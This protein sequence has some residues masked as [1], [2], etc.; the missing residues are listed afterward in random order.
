MTRKHRTHQHSGAVAVRHLSNDTIV[1]VAQLLQEQV[2]A[3][4]RF[5]VELDWFALDTDLMARDVTADV[6]L[7]RVAHGIMLRAKIA[8]TAM[9]ECVRCLEMYDQPF[10]AEAEQLYR[11]ILDL[12]HGFVV[13]EDEEDGPD[14]FDGDVGE[15]DDINEMDF[16]EPI[17]QF[18]ILSLPMQPT[19]GDDCPGPPVDLSGDDEIDRRFAPLAALLEDAPDAENNEE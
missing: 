3:T 8:G 13:G 19:C 5:K 18:A 14:G 6:E 2:G 17:R 7:M 16:A 4:R 9:I 10:V 1:N 15:I 11:P 12:H